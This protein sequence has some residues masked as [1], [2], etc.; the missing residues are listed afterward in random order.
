[1]ST[2]IVK[3]SDFKYKV[4]LTQFVYPYG[5]IAS[6]DENHLTVPQLL[7]KFVNDTNKLKSS[8]WRSM[9]AATFMRSTAWVGPIARSAGGAASRTLPSEQVRPSLQRELPLDDVGDFHQ[10]PAT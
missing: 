3:V 9:C 2:R 4:D 10:R 8:R 7:Q 1:M 5:Y 6:V